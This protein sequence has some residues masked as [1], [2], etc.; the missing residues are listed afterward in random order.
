[1][2]ISFRLLITWALIWGSG[3]NGGAFPFVSVLFPPSTPNAHKLTYFILFLITFFT[4]R[5]SDPYEFV[6]FELLHWIAGVIVSLVFQLLKKLMFSNSCISLNVFSL[7]FM[8]HYFFPSSV[9]LSCA[10]VLLDVFLLVIV[11]LWTSSNPLSSF[12][13]AVRLRFLIGE[14]C[15]RYWRILKAAS[16]TYFQSRSPI[17][18]H[19]HKATHN[20]R[21][22]YR[23]GNPINPKIGQNTSPTYKFPLRQGLEKRPRKYQK[24]N[25]PK[26]RISY[27]WGIPGGI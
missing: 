7:T 6:L 12:T 1:M 3:R 26:I 11:L 23:A 24:K 18:V 8:A 22:S 25:T 4:N 20:P 19:N 13:G 27:F 2:F 21:A 9:L 15:F 10:A 14:T 16:P 17:I 5:H